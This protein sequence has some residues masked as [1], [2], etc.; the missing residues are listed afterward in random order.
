M[1]FFSKLF[2]FV[3]AYTV[4][5]KQLCFTL[6]ISFSVNLS[7]LVAMVFRAIHYTILLFK[8]IQGFQKLFYESDE[9]IKFNHYFPD[10]ALNP[11]TDRSQNIIYGP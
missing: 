10:V 8:A 9:Q 6:R 3:F 5:S 4:I 7:T 2:I 11:I 1:L